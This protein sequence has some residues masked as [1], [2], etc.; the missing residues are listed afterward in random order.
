MSEVYHPEFGIEHDVLAL[1]TRE[2]SQL[3]LER[4][5]FSKVI[6]FRAAVIG[7]LAANQ[8]I[9]DNRVFW[10]YYDIPDEGTDSAVKLAPS[11][12]ITVIYLNKPDKLDP[13]VTMPHIKLIKSECFRR[14][15]CDEF[16]ITEVTV[17]DEMDAAYNIGIFSYSPTGNNDAFCPV[18]YVKVIDGE[19]MASTTN[20]YTNPDNLGNSQRTYFPTGTYACLS[21]KEYALGV[22]SEMLNF[23]SAL[24]PS[25]QAVN[26]ANPA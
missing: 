26:R 7:I 21:D 14:P 12:N 17:D 4:E 22:A 13:S 16:L 25:A 24:S 5:Y 6:D 18:S 23:V 10:L 2:E 20:L 15:D 1:K 3:I 11:T 19:L 8:V 9:D